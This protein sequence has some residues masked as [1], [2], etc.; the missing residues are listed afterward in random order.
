MSTHNEP[1]YLKDGSINPVFKPKDASYEPHLELTR[2]LK[3]LDDGLPPKPH[4]HYWQVHNSVEQAGIPVTCII[5]QMGK[6]IPFDA[7]VDNG[8]IVF[9]DRQ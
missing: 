9:A 2:P 1:T 8:T 4:D 3:G 7:K 6:I 5:C